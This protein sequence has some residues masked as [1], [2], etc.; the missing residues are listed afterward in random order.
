MVNRNTSFFFMALLFLTLVT[1][2][3]IPAAQSDSLTVEN[4]VQTGDI[5]IKLEEY[6]KN[7][8]GKESKYT[9]DGYVLPG[10][11]ISKIP[12][13]TNLAQPCYIRILL[14]FPPPENTQLLGLSVDNLR[15]FSDSWI[16]SGEYYYY[17]TALNTGDTLDI[18]QSVQIPSDYE[19]E[20]AQQELQISIQVD[21]IQSQNFSPDFSSQ[22]PWGNQIIEICAH[23]QREPI[24]KNPYASHYV[25]YE[26]NSHKLV[27]ASKDFFSNLGQMMPG[28]TL[29]D[30]LLLKNTTSSDAELFFRTELPDDLSEESLSLLEKIRLEIYLESELLYRGNL[31]A[32]ALG[33]NHSLGIYK[34][35]ES[36]NLTFK[37]HMPESLTNA[38]ALRETSIK[39]IFSIKNKELSISTPPPVKTGDTAVIAPYVTLFIVSLFLL[40]SF[41]IMNRK[42][43]DVHS[44]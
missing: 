13:I 17:P 28:D 1:P 22:T 8:D 32:P 44:W 36:K 16:A 37:L 14:T 35:G 29:T 7:A 11:N 9:Y 23:N 4:H 34:S 27:T 30:E 3:T 31:K 40:G 41:A 12:R 39:W 25:E 18:F 15:G 20:Y 43:E 26:G 2:L 19:N 33:K 21:A 24:I 5:N 10:D 6:Q 42:K 38:Y